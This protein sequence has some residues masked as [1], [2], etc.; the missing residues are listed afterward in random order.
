MTGLAWNRPFATG[1]L[2]L[3]AFFEGG[4]G[5]YDSY[6][7]FG[8]AQRVHGSGDTSYLGGGAI[9]RYGFS[10]GDLGRFYLDASIRAG[11]TKTDFITS[12]LRNNA[13]DSIRYDSSSPY[14]GAHFGLGYVWDL[15]E[16]AGL[17]VSL[18]YIWTR[19][20]GD[21]VTI[22]GD[23]VN[24]KAA[25]SHRLR[26]GARFSYRVNEYIRPSLG[27]YY[28]HEFDGRSRATVDGL[29]LPSPKLKG[30]TGVGELG[31]SIK[32]SQNVPFSVEL[33]VHGYTGKREG[34]TGSL[35]IKFDF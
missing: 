23:L 4:W 18:R 35:Q 13:G 32:P 25:D 20:G 7:S 27:I 26:T 19:Q 28:D 9:G 12:D 2:I 16:K 11:Q 31:L 8:N 15:T 34:V 1:N 22:G 5:S 29:S 10:Q 33:G 6:N 21:S 30:G 24:F 14:Y 3:G 17:D